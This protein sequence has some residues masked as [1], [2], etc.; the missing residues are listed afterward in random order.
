M[1]YLI[2]AENIDGLVPMKEVPE[3]IS[4]IVIPS[5][6]QLIKME[7]ENKI[8]GGLLAGQRAGAF[9][10][11][12]SSNEEVG[13]ILKA[14]PFWGMVKWKVTPLQSFKSALEQDG[15]IASLLSG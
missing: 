13:K 5:Y 3:Y 6:E 1:Q 14:I 9:V 7:A 4:H 11:E 15:S 2:E 10:M 8:K 12:A